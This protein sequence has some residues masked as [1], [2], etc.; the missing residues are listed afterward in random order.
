MIFQGDKAFYLRFVILYYNKF[1]V[2]HYKEL[3]N[4]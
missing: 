2:Y 1:C 3:L 4:N